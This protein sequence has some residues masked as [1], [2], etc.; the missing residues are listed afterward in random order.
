MSIGPLKRRSSWPSSFLTGLIGWNGFFIIVGAALGLS[1]RASDLFLLG[2]AAA[3]AQIVL[4]R[5]LF[6]ALRID[7]SNEAKE[8]GQAVDYGRDAHWL[9]P[10]FFGVVAYL[11][12]FL[13]R[14]FGLA[15]NLAVVGAMSGVV[16]AGVTHFF[17]F[18]VPRKSG[19]PVAASML[20][21]IIQG[22]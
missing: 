9:E 6:F 17:L 3:V 4:L 19:A 5:V 20:V 1:H 18:T 16:A 14:S 12:A 13:P 21:G 8:Q 10:F 15:V 11:I 2:T 22:C 7:R